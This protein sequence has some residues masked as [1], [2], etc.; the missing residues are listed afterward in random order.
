M[1]AE[2]SDSQRRQL[3]LNGAIARA[4]GRLLAKLDLRW[5]RLNAVDHVLIDLF[6]KCVRTFE[7]IQILARSGAIE[8]GLCLLRILVENTINLNYAIKTDPVAGDRQGQVIA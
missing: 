5:P 3:R 6:R 1:A 2:L 8:D 4:A 7:S